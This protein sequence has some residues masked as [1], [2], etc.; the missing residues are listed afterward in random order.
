MLQYLLLCI[1]LQSVWYHTLHCNTGRFQD[2]FLPDISLPDVSLPDISLPRH[3]PTKTF[4]YF[5]LF[6]TK[7]FPYQDIS[8]P[9]LFPTS[10]ISLPRLFPTKMFPYK[11]FSLPKLFPTKTG[12]SFHQNQIVIWHQYC[13]EH[14]VQYCTAYRTCITVLYSVQA[15]SFRWYSTAEELPVQ[16]A[17]F[18][19]YYSHYRMARHSIG[20]SVQ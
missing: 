15:G 1:L 2:V 20:R 14:V 19:M 9:R 4:P 12:S 6:P 11:D 7:T 17:S 3:F 10:D 8:L 18:S 13:T 16:I 5:R